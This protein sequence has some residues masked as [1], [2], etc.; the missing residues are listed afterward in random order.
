MKTVLNSYIL[1]QAGA[2]KIAIMK[3]GRL[4]FGTSHDQSQP[5]FYFFVRAEVDNCVAR[6]FA[7]RTR[8]GQSLNKIIG[9]INR[10]D[11]SLCSNYLRSGEYDI[12]FIQADK[13]KPL[14]TGWGKGQIA[15]TFTRSHQSP[16]QTLTEVNQILGDNFRF[17]F[18][19]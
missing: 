6:F 9:N 10:V 3:K 14:T 18:Q 16:Y 19:K 7:G 1:E 5:G 13:I 12:Y 4:P 17:K 2:E 15:M 11:C 8:T